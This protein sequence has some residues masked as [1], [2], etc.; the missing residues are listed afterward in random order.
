MISPYKSMIKDVRNFA[1][2]LK[3]ND[4]KNGR[5]NFEPRDYQLGLLKRYQKNPYT[6]VKHTRQC[7]AT[8]TTATYLLWHAL[9]KPE[10]NI[11][12][13]APKLQ[14]SFHI[15][16][17]IH[18][19]YDELTFKNYPGWEMSQS[20]K[21]SIKFANGSTI[22]ATAAVENRFQGMTVDVLYIDNC[23]F[24]PDS[25]LTKMNPTIKFDG[26]IIMTSSPG[27]TE[28]NFFEN[29]FDR[30]IVGDGKFKAFNIKGFKVPGRDAAWM[31]RM[32]SDVGVEKFKRE[33][34]WY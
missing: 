10:Q 29:L 25:V 3:I 19:L 13:C 32:K 24:I 17:E 33:F 14:S 20:S 30:A 34:N 8:V 21:T 9:T 23:A 27:F 11:V 28:D 12:V 6:I 26:K 7:G 15:L 31:K 1:R 5:T 16:E 4:P 22:S 2:Y 18:S